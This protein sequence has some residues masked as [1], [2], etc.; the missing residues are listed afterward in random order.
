[1]HTGPT[2]SFA[3]LLQSAVAE[4]G[5]LSQAYQATHR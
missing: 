5:T 1:M 3:E 2:P 4:P